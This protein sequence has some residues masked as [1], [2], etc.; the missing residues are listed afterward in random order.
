MTF[1]NNYGKIKSCFYIFYEIVIFRYV[2]GKSVYNPLIA[3]KS[4]N[5]DTFVF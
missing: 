4:P 1:S 5:S 3:G 2:F